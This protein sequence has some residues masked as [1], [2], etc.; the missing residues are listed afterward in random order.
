MPIQIHLSRLLG[1]RK[2]KIA[3]LARKAGVSRYAL[4]FLYHEQRQQISLEVLE[5]LCKALGVSVGDLLEYV[6]GD[7]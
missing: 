3:Q 6:P 4:H 1:E 7:T 2:M 5:K